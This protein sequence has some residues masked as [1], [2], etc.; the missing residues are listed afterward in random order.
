MPTD[1]NIIQFIF[2]GKDNISNIMGG[3]T[4]GLGAIVT[5]AAAA[6]AALVGLAKEQA[7]LVDIK[8]NF[9]AIADAAGY[10]G[11][12]VLESMQKATAGMTPAAD[13]MKTFNLAAN[14]VGT[15]TARLM[16]DGLG[17]I[18]K[19][20]L[21]TGQDVGYLFESLVTGVGRESKMILDNLG[22]TEDLG[23][24]KKAYAEALGIEVEALTKEQQQLAL[25]EAALAAIKEKAEPLNN[26]AGQ[27]TTAFAQ[28]QTVISDLK[29]TLGEE[30]L[31]V[32]IPFVEQLTVLAQEHLPE[33]IPLLKDFL[34][35]M[36]AAP[37]WLRETGQTINEWAMNSKI[38]AFWQKSLIVV[39]KV[40][41]NHV[42]MLILSFKNIV[43]AVREFIGWIKKMKDALSGLSLPKWLTP[44]SPTPLE[45]GLKGIS[46]QTR[47][48]AKD[49]NMLASK[50]GIVEKASGFEAFNPEIGMARRAGMTQMSSPYSGYN[51]PPPTTASGK[52][53][54]GGGGGF[55]GGFGG[56]MGGDMVVSL[57]RD[58]RDAV[59]DLPD[60]LYEVNQELVAANN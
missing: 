3:I 31:P 20:A 54:G 43:W 35:F 24:I 45:T 55:G 18:S 33:L 23:E 40:I 7:P 16:T 46:K 32:L 36:V 11:D 38:L 28:F 47:R 59:E 60:D 37:D 50:L 49:Y 29:L 12:E 21:A 52:S 41:K 30:L 51:P 10:A 57:L 44:G 53:G 4:K 13:L 9:M 6:G 2:E 8:N 39:L 25:T 26:V 48:V 17:D 5:A 22:I 1:K 42:E 56:G 19:I 27:N 14:L 58:I 34:E 15:K